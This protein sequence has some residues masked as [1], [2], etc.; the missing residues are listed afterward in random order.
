MRMA[1]IGHGPSMMHKPLGEQIDGFDVV[2]RMKRTWDLP[3][4]YPTFYGS[5]TDIVCGSLTLG[6]SMIE[7]WHERGV[8][9]FWLFSDSRHDDWPKSVERELADRFGNVYCNR[10]LCNIWRAKYITLREDIVLAESQVRS[11]GLSDEKGHKHQSAGSRAIMY[12]M[13]RQPDAIALFGFD[14][15]V[16]GEFTWSITRGPDYRKYPDHN[17]Q[18]ESRLLGEMCRHFGYTDAIYK[19]QN[20][21][22]RRAA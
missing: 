14:S 8:R 11:E 21:E 4:R 13:A 3:E 20:L 18:A 5:R 19:D 6:A 9:E 1:I 16:S 7:P 10:S 2:V 22:V 15:L 17:W 12:A